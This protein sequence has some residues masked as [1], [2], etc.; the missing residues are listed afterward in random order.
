[1]D[2]IDEMYRQMTQGRYPANAAFDQVLRT[3]KPAPSGTPLVNPPTTVNGQAVS[4]IPQ[5]QEPIVISGDRPELIEY[6]PGYKVQVPQSEIIR[7]N[8]NQAYG[9]QVQNAENLAAAADELYSERTNQKS[10]MQEALKRMMETTS[11]SF[12]DP[13]SDEAI[14]SYRSQILSAPQIPERDMATELILN[15]GPALGGMFLGES[16]KLAAPVALK[17]AR[18]LYE[19]QRKQEIDSLKLQREETEKRLKAAIE[20]RKSG[21]ESFDKSQ[22]RQ[23][24]RDKAILSGLGDVSKMTASELKDV[25]TNL[26][27]INKDVSQAVSKG[28]L[29]IAKMERSKEL[30]ENKNK[31][32]PRMEKPLKPGEVRGEPDLIPGWK[33]NKKTP[34]QQSDLSKMQKAVSD[35]DTLSN[36]MSRVAQKV[37]NASEVDLANPASGVRRDIEGDLVDAQLIYKGP[38]FAELG[39]L[40]GPDL[41]LLEKVLDPPNF[42]N[43][44]MRGGKEGALKRYEEAIGRINTKL[45]NQ[46]KYRGF[47]PNQPLGVLFV[48][49]KP[50]GPGFF[51][52]LKEKILRRGPE[53]KVINGVTYEKAEGG[54]K[55]VK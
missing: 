46:L 51:D 55:R 12:S 35:R 4:A 47:T 13:S 44:L 24:D 1:M 3:G 6:P 16:G 41:S 27:N 53:T 38:G 21:Q 25:E 28:A 36:I 15:L 9:S 39:V 29:D 54:W 26:A 42:A 40:T 52:N 8:T 20:A 30:D 10:Q 5:I 37:A 31:R 34:F 7:Q 43:A 22:Q 17:G 2:Y 50:E 45:E 48:E 33:W 49:R 11:Q 14:K 19:G 18:D 23:L 32:T